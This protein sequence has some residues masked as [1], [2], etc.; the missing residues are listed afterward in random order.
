[1]T[2]SRILIPSYFI[3]KKWVNPE[4]VTEEDSERE[5]AEEEVAEGDDGQARQADQCC[6]C[7]CVESWR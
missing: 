3:K 1:M 7:N 5:G 6:K 4:A 2:Q